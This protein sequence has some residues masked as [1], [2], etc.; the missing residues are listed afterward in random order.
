MTGIMYDTILRKTRQG[1]NEITT[2]DQSNLT[3][4]QRIQS[5]ANISDQTANANTGKMG[6]K[7]LLPG[8][9]FAEQV[10]EANTIY[11]IRDVFEISSN[12]TMPTGCTLKFTGGKLT[13]SGTL[14]FSNTII[15]GNAHIACEFAGTINGCVA[16]EWFGIKKGD[17]SFDNG[18]LI[19]KVLSV[20][21]NVSSDVGTIY[22]ST[23]IVANNVVFACLNS[24]YAFNGTFGNKSAIT[25]NNSGLSSPNSCQ[26][27]YI[28]RLTNA[29]S[30]S[31][32]YRLI[33]ETYLLS[34]EDDN[35]TILTGIT[36]NGVNNSSIE[37]GSVAYFNENVR[38]SDTL[39]IGNC[40]NT[41]K[42]G[43][44]FN[45]NV[46]VRLYHNYSGWVNGDNI[47]IL[48]ATN[49]YSSFSDGNGH[50]YSCA[51][52]AVGANASA[53]DNN[54]YNNHVFEQ[55]SMEGFDYYCMLMRCAN[56]IELNGGSGETSSSN[57]VGVI[58]CISTYSYPTISNF[59]ANRGKVVTYDDSVTV[60]NVSNA[61]KTVIFSMT[62]Q[63]ILEHLH[64]FNPS[65]MSQGYNF[66][67]D[68]DIEL[69]NRGYKG[70]NFTNAIGLNCTGLTPNVDSN[71]NLSLKNNNNLNF[72]LNTKNFKVFYIQTLKSKY[73]I[74]ILYLEDTS[75]N[76]IAKS[77]SAQIAYG[78]PL[79]NNEMNWD[80]AVNGF[81][82][83]FGSEVRSY[84]FSLLIP[85]DVGKV[86]VG[87]GSC[88]FTVYGS[89]QSN[90]F[91]DYIN[92]IGTTSQRPK[93]NISQGSSGGYLFNNTARVYAGFEYFDIDLLKKIMHN[94]T[95]WVNTDGSP[96][97][98]HTITNTLAS[99]TN[100]NPA[101][102]IDGNKTYMATLTPGLDYVIQS[103]TVTMGGTDVTSFVYNPTTH[104]I[105][106]ASVTGDIAITATAGT[107]N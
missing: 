16:L 12:F 21:K 66:C 89:G 79:S 81:T 31:T 45:S 102:S 104:V 46:H 26:Q 25:F 87:I 80:T 39:G 103:V 55:C 65:D 49:S 6:Y 60:A 86:M 1:G 19:N 94:G 53:D 33:D 88:N 98:T 37:I 3:N 57:F 56:G 7:V 58:K 107:P 51:V 50:Y 77:S 69:R 61:A 48:R 91:I 20:F 52:A 85:S 78:K 42:I 27:Y 68:N 24:T 44:S 11:E 41:Y 30:G 99:V 34:D 14:T 36:F 101:T 32:N 35:T 2:E 76:V 10:T 64:P 106:I 100:S 84:N 23:P 75:G 92:T 74:R 62:T 9:S 105:Y 47:R 29:S 93:A 40:Y 15:Q 82:A 67:F 22:F 59:Y 70:T 63:K 13:G 5:L 38:I 95:G 71:G 8:K 43:S 90:T 97:E 17:S 83:S 18:T 54:G 96:L 73:Y 28:R 72:V 4:E